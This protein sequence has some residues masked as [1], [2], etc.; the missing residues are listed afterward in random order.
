MCTARHEGGSRPV[1]RL[2]AGAAAA[3]GPLNAWGLILEPW[4]LN[5]VCS[6]HVHVQYEGGCL[7]VWKSSSHCCS[8]CSLAG[9]APNR[10]PSRP[11]I[12]KFH[13]SGCAAVGS[14]IY[15]A[16]V[17]VK[18]SIAWWTVSL[19]WLAYGLQAAASDK[20]AVLMNEPCQV[21]WCL[22]RAAV[23]LILYDGPAGKART[24][25]TVDCTFS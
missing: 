18:F 10:G 12:S 15:A 23:L 6:K 16:A 14:P 1:C 5:V 3:A 11:C 22:S 9:L 2:T 8:Y 24:D 4:L 19:V 13:I 20:G 17:V 25:D 21:R 7:C